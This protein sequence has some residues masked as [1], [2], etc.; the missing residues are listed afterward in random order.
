MEAILAIDINNGISKDGDIPWKSH[1]DMS[2]F[3]NTTVNNI[4]IMGKNT[5]FSLPEKY[6]PLK[7][8][9]NIV[10][11][12]NP[13]RYSSNNE[14]SNLFFTNNDKIYMD[15]IVNKDKYIELYPFLNNNFKI[16]F[17]GGKQIYEK[18]IHLCHT[19]WVTKFKRDFMKFNSKDN[20]I[21]F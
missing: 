13:D 9:L 12:S 19:V 20:Q 14:Y 17:I 1:K 7:N 21:Y 11:T 16:L 10:L 18:Y 15:I 4:V 3:Y 5:Y 2:F 6:R 8:R